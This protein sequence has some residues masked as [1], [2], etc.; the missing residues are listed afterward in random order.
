MTHKERFMAVLHGETPDRIP[1]AP[2]MQMWYDVYKSEGRLPPKYIGKSSAEVYAMLDVGQPG[3]DKKAKIYDKMYDVEIKVDD[4]P[5]S[6]KLTYITPYG[7]AEELFEVDQE[8]LAKGYRKS[9]QRMECMV[10][11]P[12]DFKS[13]AYIL[14]SAKFIPCYHVYNAYQAEMGDTGVATTRSEHDPF[15]DLMLQIIGLNDIWYFWNDYKEEV[16][17][18]YD[19][20]F[21]KHMNEM[22]PVI[23][24]CPA[25]FVTYGRHFDSVMTPKPIFEKYMK[26]A[27][28]VVSDALHSVGKMHCIHADAD[29]KDLLELYIESGI[30][31]LEC[32][33]T[34]PMVSVTMEETLERVGDKMVIWGGI[35][36]ALLVPHAYNQ[37][38]FL[39][40]VDNFFKVLEHYKG[41]SR[42]V[43]GLA[44]NVVP[45]ADIE[46]LEIIAERCANFKY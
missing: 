8:A 27:L 34:Y 30:D 17:K 19:I 24:A 15:Y 10:K 45:E 1:F 28:K 14:D 21:K 26:P 40:Y 5:R 33:C 22:L 6:Q 39:D 2:K 36:S 41:K 7:E 3:N 16:E 44:D 43:V 18:L 46:R 9:N 31:I 29:S 32:Y 4:Q 38:F 13:A 11:G 23:T 12:A 37:Q 25:P 42:V 20:I 35:P